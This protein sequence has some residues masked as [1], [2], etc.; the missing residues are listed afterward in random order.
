MP[1][2]PGLHQGRCE[3]TRGDGIAS[4]LAL[5]GWASATLAASQQHLG[6]AAILAALT[7]IVFLIWGAILIRD[8]AV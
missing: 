4:G 5:F 2:I 7:F 6:L 1:K 8:R 3:L